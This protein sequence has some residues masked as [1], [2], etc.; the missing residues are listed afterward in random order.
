MSQAGSQKILELQW[1]PVIS[2][3]GIV[4]R[5]LL[6]LRDVTHLR[7]LTALADQGRRNLTMIGELLGS[8]ADLCGRYLDAAAAD[9]QA[10]VALILGTGAESSSTTTLKLMFIKLHTIKGL[11]RT[12]CLSFLSA[13]A[14]QAENGFAAQWQVGA[15][16]DPSGLRRDI[17]EVE[18]VLASYQHLNTHV[19]KRNLP[20]TDLPA[21][22]PL[23]SAAGEGAQHIFTQWFNHIGDLAR[24][25]GKP[26]PQVKIEVDEGLCLPLSAVDVLTKAMVHLIRNAMDHGIE[27]PL[28]RQRSGKSPAGNLYL[29]ARQAGAWLVLRFADDGLGLDLVRLRQQAVAS[30]LIAADVQH[31]PQRLAELIFTPGLSTASGLSQTSG[32]GVGMDAVRTI[33]EQHGGEVQVIMTSISA[34]RAR[35]VFEIKIP[36]PAAQLSPGASRKTA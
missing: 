3:N 6:V 35:F 26:A 24:E 25:L 22:T 33:L 7:E 31:S 21:A 32:R 27:P 10:I 20:E 2:P 5:I 13:A 1:N 9:L 16:W 30:G 11:A 19:L 4:D 15:S 28:E 8:D 36:L 23:R 29:Q 18:A 17:A 12:L 14:H 34:D